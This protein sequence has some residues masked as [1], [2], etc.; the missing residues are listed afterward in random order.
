[1]ADLAAIPY[2]HAGVAA[3]E[4]PGSDGGSGRARS[5]AVTPFTDLLRT[6]LLPAPRLLPAADGLQVDRDAA[7]RK[8]PWPAEGAADE[9][10]RSSRRRMRARQ[11]IDRSLEALTTPPVQREAE[12]AHETPA[13]TA[14]SERAETH[15]HPPARE[16][17]GQRP[18]ETHGGARETRDGADPGE[19]NAHLI[20]VAATPPAAAQI[21]DEGGAQGLAPSLQSSAA[22]APAAGGSI[23]LL[24]GAQATAEAPSTIAVPGHAQAASIIREADTL[25]SQ[26]LAALTPAA[27][28]AADSAHGPGPR[29]RAPSPTATI[30]AAAGV[31]AIMAV[32]EGTTDLG[33]NGTLAA[34]ITGRPADGPQG[35]A[36]AT[37]VALAGGSAAVAGAGFQTV[38]S[39]VEPRHTNTGGSTATTPTIAAIGASTI[40]ASP[41]ATGPAEPRGPAG[42]G[43]GSAIAGTPTPLQTGRAAPAPSVTPPAPSIP[44]RMISDQVSVQIHKAIHDRADRIEIRL[45]PET[46]GR[47]EIRLE[48]GADNRVIA[49]VTTEQ[50]QTLELLRA[51]ARSLERALQEAGLQTDGGSLNFNLRGG[52]DG[53][54]GGRN[55]RATASF[56]TEGESGIGNAAQDMPPAAAYRPNGRSEG[57]DIRA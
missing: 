37:S 1:M 20:P 18:R 39:Q 15:A 50:R 51:D 8:N 49:T 12:R 4:R 26:P 7:D 10:S 29:Q 32:N 45:K 9:V 31:S 3:T 53:S 57:I 55:A 42:I 16:G 33:T 44:N 52:E 2:R 19:A 25:H 24:R 5:A 23:A 21:A 13:E 27:A 47:V 28:L 46:L 17:P 36:A 43:E 38:P 30:T 35:S 22:P 6:R 48:L 34:A 11:A 41:A 54:S 14:V 40:K 56:V